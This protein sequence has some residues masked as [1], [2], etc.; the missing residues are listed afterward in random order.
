MDKVNGLLIFLIAFIGITLVHILIPADIEEI[1]YFS[2]ITNLAVVVFAGF[3]IYYGY[4][5][6]K[7]LGIESPQGKAFFFLTGGY[8]LWMV[9]EFIWFLYDVTIHSVAV[10][11]PADI[12]WLLGYV[13]MYIGLYIAIKATKD[14]LN[15]KTIILSLIIF[16]TLVALVSIYLIY[17]VLSYEEYSFAEKVI[18]IVYPIG[19]LIM[20]FGAIFVIVPLLGSTIAKTWIMITG[21]MFIFFISDSVYGYLV[22]NEIYY[23]ATTQS[24]WLSGGSDV[25]YY[26]CYLLP[27][28]GFYYHLNSKVEKIEAEKKAKKE[29]NEKVRKELEE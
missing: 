2:Y 6:S 3:T 20:V 5:A 9:A 16:V 22:W 27:A 19:D 21:G 11:T 12:F 8:V 25:I 10:V 7:D 18:T 29:M 23:I 26:L 1:T 4:Q 28:L 13:L 15:K 17:P 24:Q 14:L